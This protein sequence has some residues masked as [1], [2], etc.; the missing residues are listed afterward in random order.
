MKI[1]S[2]NKE[3]AENRRSFPLRL[4]LISILLILTNED[5]ETSLS[6]GRQV[7]DGISV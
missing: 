6:T 7:Q 4:K 2:Y 1:K 5:P 3:I